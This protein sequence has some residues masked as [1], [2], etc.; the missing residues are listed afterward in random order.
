M[1]DYLKP[2][3]L[4]KLYA[5]RTIKFSLL[6]SKNAVHEKYLATRLLQAKNFLILEYQQLE[7]LIKSLCDQQITHQLF[8][9][10]Y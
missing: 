4:W 7:W 5:D 3:Q 10:R 6:V 2:I 1:E 8:F 9:E